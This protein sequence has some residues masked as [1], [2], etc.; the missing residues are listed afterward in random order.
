MRGNGKTEVDLVLTTS[1]SDDS[2]EEQKAME[3][4]QQRRPMLNLID[5]SDVPE[6]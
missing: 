1:A 3:P 5:S 6:I 4:I 2:G